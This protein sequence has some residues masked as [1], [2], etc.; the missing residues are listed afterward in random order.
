[1]FK[2]FYSIVLGVF[3]FQSFAQDHTIDSL[4]NSLKNEK[5]DSVCY[6]T[7]LKIARIYADSAYDKSLLFYNKALEIA[8][9][10]SDEKKVAN[11]YHQ[12]G[13]L[14][15]RKGDFQ[16]ALTNL[17]NA[18]TIHEYQGNKIGIGQLLN[19][20]GLIYR[21]WGKYDRA[22]ENYVKALKLFDEIGDVEN[23][24]M[25]SNNIGQV[26]YYQENYEKS[27]EFFKKYLVANK[28]SKEP[29]AYAG[30]SNN[31]ASAFMELGRLDDALEYYVR[32][33]RIYDSLGI[34]LGVAVIK[35]NIGTLFL[36]KNQYNDALLYHSDALRIFEKSGSLPRLCSS[37]QNVGLAYWKLNKPEVAINYFNRSLDIAK[38]INQ[39]ETQKDVYDALAEVYSQKKDFE[40]AY[41]YYKQFVQLK[42]SLSN[43]ETT[44][45]IE[46]LQSDYEAQKKEREIEEINHR[47]YNQKFTFILSAGLFILFIFMIF[48]IIKENQQKKKTIK[49]SLA[50]INHLTDIISKTAKN[51]VSLHNLQIGNYSTIIQSWYIGP[52]Q[53]YLG[54]SLLYENDSYLCIAFISCNNMFNHRDLVILSLYDFFNTPIELNDSIKIDNQYFN[55]ISKGGPW[56]ILSENITNYNVD[57]GIINKKIKNVSYIGTKHAYQVDCESQIINLH[58]KTSCS[59]NFMNG[60]RFYFLTINN[61]DELKQHELDF[62]L[63]TFN[64][65]LLKTTNVTFEDQKEIFNLSF[66][67]LGS[68]IH[69]LSE[70]SLS[71]FKI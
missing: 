23:G 61:Q 30:A 8:N 43:A 3:T 29:R 54:N 45:K 40:K 20:I 11:L 67:R 26:Y 14:Y 35:D 62:I 16:S 27:I 52:N 59:T 65:T 70:V 51:V 28:R 12:I 33:M 6:H 5:V 58:Q 17:N 18:L 53:D 60:D 24:A 47:L 66:K 7:C 10:L 42:D 50:Q 15:Q 64:E 37:L 63:N 46:T 48:L 31:I 57:F 1:M 21:T 36:R 32:S 55:F 44:G 19:D 49:D 69:D 2:V 9:K 39:K 25:V 22:L 56:K 38:S 68:D 34:K 71:A 13:S 41:F 4:I